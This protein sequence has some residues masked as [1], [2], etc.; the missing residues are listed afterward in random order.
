MNFKSWRS[1]W[2]FVHSVR[3]EGR[4]IH[5]DEVKIFLNTV[6]ESSVNRIKRIPKDSGLW[7]A[8]LGMDWNEQF[9][10]DGSSM[11]EFPYPYPARR[12]KPISS[13]VSDGR[14]N[15][16]GVAFLYLAS[17]K[18]T[19]M[20]EIRPWIGSSISLGHFKINR[21]I[22]VVDC[23]LYHGEQ[24]FYF[25]VQNPE[26]EPDQDFINK[27]VWTHID[28]AFSQPVERSQSETEYLPTQII[29]ELF[30]ANKFDGIVYR[31]KFSDG[32][33]IVLFDIGVADLVS[34]CIY[35]VEEINF[36]FKDQKI[37]YSEPR[38]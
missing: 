25:N 26:E 1:Y 19:A 20:A 33:N 31:S 27:A 11:G 18:E 36:E 4:Y 38:T 9:Q 37:G 8:Q 13:L 10:D 3:N 24:P 28:N 16:K 23:S 22:K 7:R 12:M 17:K 5:S 2:S 14:V 35:E 15:P 29:A 32:Y 6:L 30:K 34:C 21:D